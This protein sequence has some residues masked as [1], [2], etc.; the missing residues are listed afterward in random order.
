VEIEGE[1]TES[2]S[3]NGWTKKHLVCCL[4]PLM[5]VFNRHSSSS[6]PIFLK[7]PIY[8]SKNPFFSSLSQ[9]CGFTH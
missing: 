6:T 8:F 7:I 3:V 9:Q 1:K 2:G 4:Q 5:F